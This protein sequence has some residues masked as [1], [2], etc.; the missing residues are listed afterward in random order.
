LV[1]NGTLLDKEYVA[2]LV[3]SG[4]HKVT[5]GLD[6]ATK[7]THE[8]FRGVT[9]SFEKAVQGTQ[10]LVDSGIRVTINVTLHDAILP[11]LT[12]I[13]HLVTELRVQGVS[14]VFP[15]NCGRAAANSSSFTTVSQKRDFVLAKLQSIARTLE[16]PFR[17][18]VL[19]PRCGTD[20]CP[21]NQFVFWFDEKNGFGRCLF[22]VQN[23]RNRIVS[24][25][26]LMV[27]DLHEGHMIA[28]RRQ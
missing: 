18:Q 1:T 11:E 15:M 19:D 13:F 5:V 26:T 24:Q 28:S 17:L 14:F 22:D 20:S 16:A 25:Q 7:K 4:L 27:W 3:Q 8:I 12:D 2:K 23:N 10:V 21:S 9:G 6:G